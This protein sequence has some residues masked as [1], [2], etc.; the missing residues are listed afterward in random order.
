MLSFCKEGTVCTYGKV[1]KV[2]NGSDVYQFNS[3]KA[4]SRNEFLSSLEQFVLLM[5]DAF[6]TWWHAAFVTRSISRDVLYR[7]RF[8]KKNIDNKFCNGV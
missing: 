3:S 7:Y 6:L 2:Q 4:E 1:D 8:T 5:I